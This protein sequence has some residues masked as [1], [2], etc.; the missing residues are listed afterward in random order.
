M[1]M[2]ISEIERMIELDVEREISKIFEEKKR[3]FGIDASLEVGFLGHAPI[4]GENVYGEAFPPEKR[5]VLEVFAPDATT[6]SIT[7]IICHELVHVE[8]PELKEECEEFRRRVHD[9]LD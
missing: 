3:K 6:E 8:H 7:E 4:V 1:A 5:V 9:V 2:S